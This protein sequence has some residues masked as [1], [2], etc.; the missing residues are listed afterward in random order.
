MPQM[1]SSHFYQK[2]QS[3]LLTKWVTLCWAFIV[4]PSKM[5]SEL[6]SYRQIKVTHLT[7]DQTSEEQ[8]YFIMSSNGLKVNP[9]TSPFMTLKEMENL[10]LFADGSFMQVAHVCNTL[11]P[12]LLAFLGTRMLKS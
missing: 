3:L 10:A 2:L 9:T 11:K 12:L 1:N 8:H 6:M 7:L 5:I 4:D